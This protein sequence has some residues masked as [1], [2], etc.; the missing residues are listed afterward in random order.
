MCPC[1]RKT[2][3]HYHIIIFIIVYI[4]LLYIHEL[5]FICVYFNENDHFHNVN[6]VNNIVNDV[7]SL[8]LI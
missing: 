2:A 3:A 6:S 7:N 4:C 8:R 1:R 5:D